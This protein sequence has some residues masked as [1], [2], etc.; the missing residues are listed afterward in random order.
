[1]KKK[2]RMLEIELKEIKI[3]NTKTNHWLHIFMTL[4]TGGVWVFIWIIMGIVNTRK[5]KELRSEVEVL[6]KYL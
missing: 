5:R 3:N 6:K 4:L 2:E 1:M